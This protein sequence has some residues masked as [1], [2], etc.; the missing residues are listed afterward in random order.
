ME[1]KFK[2]PTDSDNDL[3]ISNSGFGGYIFLTIDDEDSTS[4]FRI[5]LSDISPLI[6]MLELFQTKQHIINA[7]LD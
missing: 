7:G 3:I 4:D 5:S 2:D 6:K 1:A